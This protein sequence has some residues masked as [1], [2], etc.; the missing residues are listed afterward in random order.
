MTL[1]E[2]IRKEGDEELAALLINWMLTIVATMGGDYTKL[3]L[4]TEF[5][6]LISYLQ[7]PID[8][9]TIEA[10]KLFITSSELYS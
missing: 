7:M 9:E 10:L 4:K 6:E 5:E 3:N 1:G 2:W 8:N